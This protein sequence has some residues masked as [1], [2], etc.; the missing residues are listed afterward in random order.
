VGG[1]VGEVTINTADLPTGRGTVVMII[2][3]NIC[4]YSNS[5]YDQNHVD[6]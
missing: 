1:E 3:N 2:S 4:I 5:N 6:V